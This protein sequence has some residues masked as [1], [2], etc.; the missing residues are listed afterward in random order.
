MILNNKNQKLHPLIVFTALFILLLTWPMVSDAACN[1]Q[2][3]VVTTT[4]VYDRT[5]VFSTAKGWVNGR[6]V[7]RLN[8]GSTIYICRE[9]EIRFGFESQAWA[10]ISYYHDQKWKYGWVL[11]SHLSASLG[12]PESVVQSDKQSFLSFFIK[13]A[14]ADHH[15]DTA[16]NLTVDAPPAGVPLPT[17]PAETLV[18]TVNGTDTDSTPLIKFYIILFLVMI[19]GM[20]AK[21]IFDYVQDMDN[22]SRK[23][24][25]R[26]MIRPLLVSPI[27]FLT[28][29][30]TAEFTGTGIEGF[31]V[32]SLFS[33]QNGFFWQTVLVRKES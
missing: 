3:S 19:A 29:M 4:N 2:K 26:Q 32:I 5:P 16:G 12:V 30:Q 23:K 9:K 28:F 7:A 1:K 25:L 15:E 14:H 31:I 22:T 33:F 24:L 17:A 21:S 13:T 20:I 18:N 10:Q 27:V 8:R 11:R 6:R